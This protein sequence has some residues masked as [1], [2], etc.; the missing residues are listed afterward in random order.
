M[1]SREFDPN[2][3]NRVLIESDIYR[4]QLVRYLSSARRTLTEAEMFQLSKFADYGIVLLAELA[5]DTSGA[6]RNARDLAAQVELPVP[7]VSKILKALARD[8][9]L[10]SQRGTK[11]GYSMTCLPEELSVADMIAALDRPVAITECNV[12]PH[13]CEHEGSCAVRAPWQRINRVVENA[14]RAVTLRDLID[15]GI[16][17]LAP[18]HFVEPSDESSGPSRPSGPQ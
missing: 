4:T 1:D 7:I 18:V 6:P 13:L 5:K 9:L 3:F 12:G 10:Q 8:G 2:Q 16:P 11:G 17:G 15:P 14:L